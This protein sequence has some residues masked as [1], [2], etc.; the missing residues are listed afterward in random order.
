MPHSHGLLWHR[1]GMDY[2]VGVVRRKFIKIAVQ[3]VIM[4]SSWLVLSLAAACLQGFTRMEALP[5][6]KGGRKKIMKALQAEELSKK[7]EAGQRWA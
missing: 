7:A 6:E 5:R 1:T 2:I 3:V 4:I